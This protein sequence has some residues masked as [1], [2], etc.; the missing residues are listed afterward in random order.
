MFTTARVTCTPLIGG[1]HY[2]P[3]IWLWPITRTP[4][5]HERCR[6]NE[7]RF[8][9]RDRLGGLRERLVR[10]EVALVLARVD[11][12]AGLASLCNTILFIIDL[13]LEVHGNQSC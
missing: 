11:Y 1:V 12:Q 13:P 10:N 4:V 6:V 2:A 5:G 3:S 7:K 8:V 9:L